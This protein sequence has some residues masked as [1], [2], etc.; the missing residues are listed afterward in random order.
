MPNPLNDTSSTEDRTLKDLYFGRVIERRGRDFSRP[1]N[2]PFSATVLD[3][4]RRKWYVQWDDSGPYA[5]VQLTSQGTA[6]A[7]YLAENA[8]K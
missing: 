5:K 1:D 2:M 6:V 3:D 4:L 7:E 8:L